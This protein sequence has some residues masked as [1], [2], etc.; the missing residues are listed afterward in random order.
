MGEQNRL[1]KALR[2]FFRAKEPCDDLPPDAELIINLAAIFS[3]M[4]FPGADQI[5][6]RWSDP[7][8]HLPWRSIV[9]AA[10]IA[11]SAAAAVMEIPASA[12]NA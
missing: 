5:L 1:R 12:I 2:N 6:R 4:P 11:A 8:L 9:T 10:G 3:K 7:P